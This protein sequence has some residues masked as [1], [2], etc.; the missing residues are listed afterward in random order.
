MGL[1]NVA[2]DCY[3]HPKLKLD[4]FCTIGDHLLSMSASVNCSQLSI[5]RFCV[6]VILGVALPHGDN[7]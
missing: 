6:G 7:G 1:Q 5:R 2:W 4:E 3:E